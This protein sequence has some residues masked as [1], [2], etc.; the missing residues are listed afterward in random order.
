[1]RGSLDS[2]ILGQG[3]SDDILFLEFHKNGEF[4]DW[5]PVIMQ[6]V[7]ESLISSRKEADFK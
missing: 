7:D 3:P 5:M 6:S 4:L 2:A 1:M